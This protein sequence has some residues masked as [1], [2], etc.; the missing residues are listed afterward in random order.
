MNAPLRQMAV[1]FR[2]KEQLSYSEIRRRLGVSKSTLSYWLKEYPLS[3]KQ[4]RERQR[5][6]WKNAEAG[7]ERFRATMRRKREA[8]FETVYQQQRRRLQRFSHQSFF[9]AGLMLYVAEGDKKNHTRIALAN[10][11]PAVIR[12]FSVAKVLVA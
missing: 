1:D 4:I 2:L 5:Q 6:G 3:E 11:D 7:R 10:T 12:F 8:W 9:V